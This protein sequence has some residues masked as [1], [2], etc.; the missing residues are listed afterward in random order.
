MAPVFVVVSRI[1]DFLFG[2]DGIIYIAT[3]ISEGFR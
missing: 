2:Y 3:M 1:F